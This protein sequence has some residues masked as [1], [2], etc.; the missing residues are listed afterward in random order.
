MTSTAPLGRHWLVRLDPYGK[1][2]AGVS[3]IRCVGTGCVPDPTRYRDPVLA[4]TQALA[5]V[6][7]HVA[8][9]DSL[10]ENARCRCCHEG[11]TWHTQQRVECSGPINLVLIPDRLGRM[12]ILA[13]T[14]TACARAVPRIKVIRGPQPSPP[15]P[16][17]PAPHRRS[18]TGRAST[19]APS[20]RDGAPDRDRALN[21]PLCV[22]EQDSSAPAAEKN[23]RIG[24]EG[25]EV[26]E[27][28]D[29]WPVP[30]SFGP[31]LDE[32]LRYLEA[33]QAGRSP[34]GRLLALVCALRVR[35]EG[36]FRMV[37]DDLGPSRLDIPMW[38]VDELNDCRWIDLDPDDVHAAVRGAPAAEGRLPHLA[39]GTACLGIT[40]LARGRFN[41][42]IQ[43]MVHHPLLAGQPAAVRLGALYATSQC[44][45]TGHG[46][47]VPRHMAERCRYDSRDL[48]RPVLDDLH[49]AGWLSRVVPGGRT[50]DP[51]RITVAR[52]IRDL[53]PRKG[54]TLADS[55]TAA[56]NAAQAI[57]LRGREF[58]IA[59]W[60]EDYV[61]RHRHGPRSRDVIA[62]HIDE[63]P[64]KPWTVQM[65][66]ETISRLT[67]Q[68]WLYT[69]GCRWYRTRP[70]LTYQRRLAQAR[71]TTPP[72]PRRTAGGARSLDTT[73]S[74]VLEAAAMGS[75]HGQ[76]SPAGQP[77][78]L[79][80]I[81][82]AEAILGP[83]P[84]S[85]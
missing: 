76:D 32:A 60:V 2:A 46:R 67:Q 72:S 20:A 4:R 62:S 74:P 23:E 54:I 15:S 14:C 33:V 51:I 73:T 26:T 18:A 21:C 49:H 11:C 24:P 70:G 39:D 45:D 6:R 79:W 83:R 22:Q 61:A 17:R 63:D 56:R 57:D 28:P 75:Q 80:L 7:A 34:E 25:K 68:G 50:G 1:P 58:A 82:G 5:H 44:D 19:P 53:V 55:N 81:P 41:G 42:W 64:N 43:R 30:E 29:N 40:G 71:A 78:G 77:S 59:R 37:S 84:R 10:R 38:A 16:V 47:I 66:A 12:W 9:I 8:Q 52:A 36:L 31:S 69:D 27:G 85:S 13:E 65:I 48:A 3:V 35:R